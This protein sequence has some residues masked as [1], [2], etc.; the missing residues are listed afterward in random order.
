[1]SIIETYNNLN[2]VPAQ[3]QEKLNDIRCPECGCKLDIDND[4]YIELLYLHEKKAK[5]ASTGEE[6]T[7]KEYENYSAFIGQKPS[8]IQISMCCTNDEEHENKEYAYF[9]LEADLRNIIIK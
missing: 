6:I 9:I 5:S 1:M 3:Q 8:K 4:D 2:R 7:I